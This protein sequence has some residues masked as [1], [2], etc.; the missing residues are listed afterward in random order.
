M[1]TII[2]LLGLFILNTKLNI[3][4]QMEYRFNFFLTSIIALIFSSISPLLQ[5]LIF[6]QTKGFPGWNLDQ[7]ILFQGVLLIVLGLQSLLFGELRW[8]ITNLVWRG[9][10]DRLLLKPYPPIGIIL[11]SGFSLNI[12]GTILAGIAITVYSVLKMQL[13]ISFY[14]IAL[15]LIYIV[16][17][18]ILAMALNVLFCCMVIVL[19]RLG[20]MDE[21]FRVLA[22]FGDYPIDIYSNAL[23][24]VFTTV[25]PFAIWA[26]VPSKVLLGVLDASMIY[27]LVSTILFFLASLKLWD[28]CLKKYTSAGG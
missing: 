7:I 4:R 1:K 20:R 13:I 12:T 2:R 22:R 27:S 3:A 8:F 28:I 25:V 5:Y 21:I 26:Y 16:V 6:T 23:R 18:L 9:E 11:A 10:L 15:F 24:F 19:V 17:G 14:Q